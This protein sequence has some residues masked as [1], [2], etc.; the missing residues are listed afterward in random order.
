MRPKPFLTYF[1]LCAIPLLLL[2]GLNY[3]NSVRTVNSMLA[4]EA[5]GDLMSFNVSVDELLDDREHDIRSFTVE[6]PVQDIL[7]KKVDPS[8]LKAVGDLS[9]YFQS[10]TIFGNDRKALGFQKGSDE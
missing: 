2:A 5:Q 6:T 3:W 9:R 10:I 8:S 4:T 7:L 1:I